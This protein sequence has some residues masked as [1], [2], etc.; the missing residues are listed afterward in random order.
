LPIAARARI[1]AM[2]LSAPAPQPGGSAR[3][4]SA[5]VVIRRADGGPIGS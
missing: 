4:R 2:I 1:A 5:S 3:P